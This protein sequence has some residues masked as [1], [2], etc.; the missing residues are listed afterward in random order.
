VAQV[1][2]KIGLSLG[3]D[4]C[5]PKCYEDIVAKLDLA[6]PMGRDKVR[7]QVERMSIEPY[8]LQAAAKYDVVVDRLTHW[9]APTREWIKKAILLDG[10]YVFNNP[11]SVQSMEKHTTYAAMMALGIPIPKTAMIP[12]KEY[13]PKADLQVTLQRYAKL[14]N[15]GQVGT[16]VGYPA[17]MKPY[18]GGGWQGVTKIDNEDE[19]REAYEKS[20][21]MVMHLQKGVVPYDLF[22]RC[23][24]FGPQTK[25]IKYDPSAPLHGR[26]TTETGFIDAKD[27]SLIEDITLTINAFFGWDFNSCEALLK[28]HVWH[29]IDF[30]NPCPDSQIT[31]LHQHFPWLVKSYIRWSIFCAATKRPMRA[32]LDWQPFFDVKK[33]GLPYRETVA[34]YAKIARQRLDADKFEEFCAKHLS[35]LDDV[36]NEY[37]GTEECREIFRQKVTAL[38]PAHEVDHFT[39][40]FFDEVQKWRAADTAER[41]AKPH[42]GGKRAKV[43]VSARPSKKSKPAKTLGQPKAKVVAVKARVAKSKP[44]AKTVKSAGSKTKMSAATK[45]NGALSKNTMSKNAASK[46]SKSSNAKSSKAKVRK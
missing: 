40:H 24:G 32:A 9:Y 37:F 16:D 44:S 18:D 6:I 14:F 1:T 4:L 5:W 20:G 29:P 7:F 21:K 46:N 36:A 2:R 43:V 28:D 34:A 26:Y 41:S 31:S 39:A 17:F 33:K 27:Q 10:T 38:F 25:T 12:P 13:E 15:L 30:A 3:A 8:D 23:I 42:S 45:S 19:L 35:H 11:W 22:V